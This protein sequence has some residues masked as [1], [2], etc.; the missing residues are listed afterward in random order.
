MLPLKVSHYMTKKYCVSSNKSMR[1]WCKTTTKQKRVRGTKED[2]LDTR[3]NPNMLKEIFKYHSFSLI[4]IVRAVF[5][6]FL[7]YRVFV[8]F[9][10]E[11]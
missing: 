4:H 3:K 8:G 1:R 10:C 11:N 9:K 2:N 5:D 6:P 7:N